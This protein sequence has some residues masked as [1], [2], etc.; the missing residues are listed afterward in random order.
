[1]PTYS[2]KPPI[3]RL[4]AKEISGE[5]PE[6]K[7]SALAFCGIKEEELYLPDVN[8]G[9]PWLTRAVETTEVCSEIYAVATGDKSHLY[10]YYHYQPDRS[11]VG[12]LVINEFPQLKYA[13]LKCLWIEYLVA[14]P[15]TGDV[16]PTMLEYAVN[17]SEAG[18]CK[19]CVILGAGYPDA[20]EFYKKMGFK[21]T[22]L[23]IIEEV[24]EGNEVSDYEYPIMKL[25]PIKQIAT[26]I[27]SGGWR[28]KTMNRRPFY[29]LRP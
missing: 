25:N 13:H 23:S 5:M 17:L 2:L 3:T 7:K 18:T 8:D 11:P 14:H 4:T 27:Y 22:G 29:F 1:M 24:G 15:G 6:F 19:G 10:S 16:G 12:F 21:G 26:W 28:L 9:N 20:Q